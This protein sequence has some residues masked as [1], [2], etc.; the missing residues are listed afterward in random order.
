MKKCFWL[1]LTVVCVLLRFAF[2]EAPALSEP[3]QVTGSELD[4]LNQ[5]GFPTWDDPTPTPNGDVSLAPTPKPDDDVSLAPTPEPD[6]DVSLAPTPKPTDVPA[7]TPAHNPDP[8]DA[9]TPVPT[10]AH[11]PDPTDA[12]TQVPTASPAPTA[13]PHVHVFVDERER[14]AEHPHRYFARCSCGATSFTGSTA[15]D[16]SCCACGYHKYQG[17]VCNRCGEAEPH[18]H[19]YVEKTAVAHPHEGYKE[20]ECGKI[21]WTSPS[22][23]SKDCCECGYHQYK[24]GSCTRCGAKDPGATAVP[25]TQA[26]ATQAPATK[27]PATATPHV[28]HFNRGYEKA[29]PHQFYQACACG[30]VEYLQGQYA[31]V[32]TCCECGNHSYQNGVCSRCK[33]KQPQIHEHLYSEYQH[34]EGTNFTHRAYCACGEYQEINTRMMGC[35]GC[36]YHTPDG[37]SQHLYRPL[38]GLSEVYPHVP[39]CTQCGALIPENLGAI[40]SCDACYP[41]K[42]QSWNLEVG[43]VGANARKAVNLACNL[44]Y[45]TDGTRNGT[46]LVYN[47]GTGRHEYV[48]TVTLDDGTL[49]PYAYRIDEP[50]VDCLMRL[51]TVGDET[52]LTFAFEGTQ[53]GQDLRMDLGYLPNKQGIHS[54]I[55][56]EYL[57]FKK[58]LMTQDQSSIFYEYL[59]NPPENL[60]I[61]LTGHSLGGALSQI[62]AYDLVTSY[63]IGAEKIEGYTF[64]S[65]IPFEYEV[66]E[67]YPELNNVTMYNFIN[68][69]DI[70]P[71][72]GVGDG[73]INSVDT[74]SGMS[75][76]GRNMGKNVY[77]Q[78][79]TTLLEGELP[80]TDL[81]NHLS[82]TYLPLIKG[83]GK[84]FDYVIVENSQYNQENWKNAYKDANFEPCK[85]KLK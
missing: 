19:V 54:G 43:D 24:N 27:A 28:H 18:V 72:V 22:N 66:F 21:I 79:E 26:P 46:E 52:V 48:P 25:V 50:Y 69:L 84:D 13:T 15:V 57:A 41:K 12:P 42:D 8:T 44:V 20:C 68:T 55:Y 30:V 49:I 80:K 45:H 67:K 40:L 10:P 5:D 36:G 65:P 77:I 56:D 81:I 58:Q 3:V 4:D 47:E 61:Q 63:G 70:V 38:A 2:F 64:A 34:L 75:S 32:N 62:M 23:K 78:R 51:E 71:K 17:G 83:I 16:T 29:H 33:Q 39:V 82:M 6:D 85:V 31:T 35:C 59:K 73:K 53:E 7:N 14:E 37:V 60:R 9:P 11:N 1:C 76:K 74:P